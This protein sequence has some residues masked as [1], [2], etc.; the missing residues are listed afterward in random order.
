MKNFLAGLKKDPIARKLLYADHS[1][2]LDSEDE[3][4]QDEQ[5]LNEILNSGES[6]E[7]T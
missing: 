1:A 2:D 5:L 6:Q 3:E 7:K 4:D